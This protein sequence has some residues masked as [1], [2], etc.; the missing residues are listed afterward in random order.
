M[1]QQDALKISQHPKYK[2]LVATRTRYSWMMTSFVFVIYF[3]FIYLVAFHKEYLAQRISENSVITYSIP[4]GIGV[5]LSTVILTGIYVFRA[6]KEFD[7]LTNQIK[8]DVK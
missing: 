3:G 1:K 8:R 5:I 6:N 7:G 4:F 2:E